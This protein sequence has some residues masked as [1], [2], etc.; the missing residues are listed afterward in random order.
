M[1]K[2]LSDDEKHAV[3]SS[4]YSEIVNDRNQMSTTTRAAAR[5]EFILVYVS[6]VNGGFEV[7]LYGIEWIEMVGG[8][9]IYSVEDVV[10]D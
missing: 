6:F 2:I 3:L 1:T 7:V 9:V 5:G 4:V 10:W 8:Y